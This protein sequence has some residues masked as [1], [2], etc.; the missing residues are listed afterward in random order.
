ML[1]QCKET[2]RELNMVF[3]EVLTFCSDDAEKIMAKHTKA[4]DEQFKVVDV[5]GASKYR[6]IATNRHI[7]K[8][9]KKLI[10]RG[11]LT[12]YEN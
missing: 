6:I 10:K 9:V 4:K 3:V 1:V 5:Q 11:Y 7:A 2:K 12:T 8:I